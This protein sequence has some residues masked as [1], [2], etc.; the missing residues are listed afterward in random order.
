MLDDVLMHPQETVDRARALSAKGLFDR[1]VERTTRIPSR[2]V[3]EWHTWGRR[4]PAAEVR[5]AR[6]CPRCD[7]VPLDASAYAYLLGLFLGD[8]YLT[9]RQE[10]GY[11]LSIACADAWPGLIEAAKDATRVVMPLSAV[12]TRQCTGMTEVKSGSRHWPCL[13]PQH[14]PG[15]KHTR[16]A[17][18]AAWQQAIVDR[19]PG[20]LA[21][22]LFHSDGYRGVNRV[23]R[24]LADGDHW[25][26]YPRY[27]FSNKSADILGLCGAALDRLG[28]AWRFAR[29]DVISVAKRAAVARL[30]EF[31]GPKY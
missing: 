23:R 15:M 9:C 31:V 8:G 19:H 29:P 7:G 14:D 11:V 25:Y 5:R 24:V 2:T 16:K 30:D 1:Q 10:D 21:R 27:L 12:F 28:V 3:R 17:E 22:G 26:A 13:F 4:S 20:D 18:L 6:Y